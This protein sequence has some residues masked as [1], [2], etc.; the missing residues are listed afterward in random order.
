MT[1]AL[2]SILAGLTG[3]WR[4]AF[5]ESVGAV[6]TVA[7]T[8]YLVGTA[9]SSSIVCY[10]LGQ[11]SA[12]EGVIVQTIPGQ[13]DRVWAVAGTSIFYGISCPAA[14][15][16]YAA[17]PWGRTRHLMAAWWCLSITTVR[18]P[19]RLP[20][21]RVTRSTA[22]RDR[23]SAQVTFRW[24]VAVS[25]AVAGF[26]LYDGHTRINSRLIP[27]H[28]ARAYR[29]VTRWTGGGPFQLQ[30]LFQDGSKRVAPDQAH[31]RIV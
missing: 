4:H 21:E 11:S 1:L 23:A 5:A 12:D 25:T 20:R 24:R 2:G 28:A 9:C 13:P 18:V 15:T 19:P 30:V 14:T 16:C 6:H 17:M 29:Y 27:V 7:G 26:N 31:E 3:T 8:N 22:S 10:A